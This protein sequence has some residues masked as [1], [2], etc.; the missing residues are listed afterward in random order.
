MD[1][2]GKGHGARLL[3]EAMEKAWRV[4]QQVGGFGLFVDA[5]EG[6]ASFYE[7]YGFEPFPDDPAT[8][9]LRISDIGPYPMQDPEE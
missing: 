9:V 2:K 8:L 3:N 6:A 1:D 7:H 4:A 5:K